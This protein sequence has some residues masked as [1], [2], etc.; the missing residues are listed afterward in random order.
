[1]KLFTGRT[2]FYLDADSAVTLGKFDGIHRGHQLLMDE[3]EAAGLE[4]L[5]TVV[6]TFTTHPQAQLEGRNRGLLLTNEEKREMFQARN[7][8]ILVEFPFN[9]TT[10]HISP[11]DFVEQILVRQ[12]RAKRI[13]TGTDFGFGYRRAGNVELLEQL[14]GRYGY[15]LIVK[16]KLKTDEGIDISSTYIR[17]LL[18]EGRIDRVNDLL[19]YPYF[20]RTGGASECY[21]D[22]E[23]GMMTILQIPDKEK[24]MPAD[25]VYESLTF[26]DGRTF[27]TVTETGRG[28][29]ADIPGQAYAKTRFTDFETVPADGEIK[30]QLLSLLHPGRMDASV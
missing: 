8:D 12:L 3:L 10:S 19:G 5:K 29:S 13:I 27:R 16:E 18:S 25:G 7:F 23:T 6:F 15:E 9:D 1:M 28:D 22:L 4:G 24:L 26:A 17:Q 11:E 21:R 14:S 30:V 20:I 2:D